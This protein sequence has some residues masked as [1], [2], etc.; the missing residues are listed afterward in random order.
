M[1]VFFLFFLL[2]LVGCGSPDEVTGET[3]EF[4]VIAR[5]FEFE[6]S[7][8]TVNLGD[9]VIIHLTSEDDGSGTGHGIV[10]TAFGVQESI[11]EGETKTVEFIADKKG[12]HRMFC[13]IYC[14]VG[15]GNM[16][17]VLIVQ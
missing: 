10:I 4:D 11:R 13:Q 16:A 9:K 15:H 1:K 14:G 12:K 5:N 2:F 8:I 3:K 7:T 17:G 6:P